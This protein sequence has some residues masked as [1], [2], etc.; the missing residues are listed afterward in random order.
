MAKLIEALEGENSISKPN[1]QLLN[2]LR[3]CLMASL[4]FKHKLVKG[5]KQ[6][7]LSRESQ[8]PDYSHRE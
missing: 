6:S 8:S 2:T 7:T 5:S 4:A 1:Q 3:R